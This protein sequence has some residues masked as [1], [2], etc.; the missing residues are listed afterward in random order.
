[1]A[2]YISHKL[3]RLIRARGYQRYTLSALKEQVVDLH[4]NLTQDLHQQL[5]Q[6]TI[7]EPVTSLIMNH[8]GGSILNANI[9]DCWFQFRCKSTSGVQVRLRNF[10][11]GE[12]TGDGMSGGDVSYRWMRL[13]RALRGTGTTCGDSKA[14][15]TPATDPVSTACGCGSTQ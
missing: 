5:T 2:N 4:L 1:M 12:S 14:N 13:C 6:K 7:L 3:S 15:G 11:A 8:L 9:Y 10:C